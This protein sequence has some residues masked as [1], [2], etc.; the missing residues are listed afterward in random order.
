MDT[1]RDESASVSIDDGILVTG[2]TDDGGNRLKT[3][4]IVF[5]NGT[6]KKGKPLPEPKYGHCLV[7]YQGQI[8]STGGR[9]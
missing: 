4:E 5:L 1:P 9:N 6:V 3:S 7:E 8:I 2:G